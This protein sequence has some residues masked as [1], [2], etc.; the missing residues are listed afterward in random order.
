MT[1][2]AEDQTLERCD[3][4]TSAVPIVRRMSCCVSMCVCTAA[5]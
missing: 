1:D 2:V 5:V 4:I 3:D